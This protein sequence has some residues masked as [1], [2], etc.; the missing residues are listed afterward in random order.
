MKK[1]CIAAAS[2][3]LGILSILSLILAYYS[4]TNSLYRYNNVIIAAPV[5]ALAGLILS[6]IERKN[7][8]EYPILWM[9]GLISSSISTVICLLLLL[10]LVLVGRILGSGSWM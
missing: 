5:C 4:A 10:F 1:K 2:L 7:R 8:K 3:V 6:I 9:S